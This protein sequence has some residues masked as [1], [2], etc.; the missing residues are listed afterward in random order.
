M[1]ADI[2]IIMRVFIKKFTYQISIN[3]ERMTTAE[4]AHACLVRILA[5][6]LFISW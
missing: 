3:K 5:F 6:L 1:L 2:D 4:G